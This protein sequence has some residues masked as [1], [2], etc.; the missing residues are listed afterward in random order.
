MDTPG[1]ARS[2]RAANIELMRVWKCS[3]LVIITLDGAL[4]QGRRGAPGAARR[5][6]RGP[7]LAGGRLRA[8]TWTGAGFAAGLARRRGPASA[9]RHGLER[10]GARPGRQRDRGGARVDVRQ[11]LLRQG[12]GRYNQ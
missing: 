1:V 7:A 10:R 8:A 6:A 11:R 2:Q 4:L 9:R 3:A 5:S 12:G